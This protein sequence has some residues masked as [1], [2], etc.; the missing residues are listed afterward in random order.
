MENVRRESK[1]VLR[2]TVRDTAVVLCVGGKR[3]HRQS[4]D[5]PSGQK[6]GSC[7]IVWSLCF[8]FVVFR[9]L[10]RLLGPLQFLYKHI[11]LLILVFFLSIFMEL[12]SQT[13]TLAFAKVTL[14]KRSCVAGA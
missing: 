11:S 12:M 14:G 5:V 2:E 13:S 9:D 8:H 1:S 4:T 6:S 7:L 10:P 3:S